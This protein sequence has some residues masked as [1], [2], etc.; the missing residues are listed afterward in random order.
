MQLHRDLDEIH[1]A[2]AELV[3]IGN[4]SPHFIKGFREEVKYDGKLYTDPSLRTYALAGM[5]RG[6]MRVLNPMG[7]FRAVRAL[8]RG[9]M[10]TRTKGDTSQQ[11]GVIVVRP[12]GKMPFAHADSSPGDLA[13]NDKILAALRS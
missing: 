5:K 7:A 3:V 1:A 10:Q 6:F 11:G 9:A 2:G 13:K 8:S 4:G 12:D